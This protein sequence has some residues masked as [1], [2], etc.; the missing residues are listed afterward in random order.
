MNLFLLGSLAFDELYRFDGDF[1]ANLLSQSLDDLSVCFVTGHHEFSFGGCGGN[2][3]FGLHLLACE[4]FV[5]GVLG[6]VDG[7]VYLKRLQSYGMNLNYLTLETGLSSRAHILTDKKGRQIS[8]FNPG[9]SALELPFPSLDLA[10]AG[11]VLFVSPENKNRMMEAAKQGAERG[12]RVFFDPGQMIHVFSKEDYLEIFNMIELLI[13]NHYEWKLLQDITGMNEEELRSKV[14]KIVLTLSSKG[15]QYF[16]EGNEH[17]VDA[18]EVDEANPTGSGE[19]FRA[20]LL[21]S[22]QK[23]LSFEEGLN[24]GS[25]LGAICASHA[26]TQDYSFG[27]DHMKKLESLGFFS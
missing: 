6:N 23:G 10:K 22:L 26:K 12:M 20:G 16:T 3:A 2:L 8:H 14:S 7:E 11:D 4:A 5:I 21:A 27:P 9:V 19:A 25:I 13:L 15:A 1:K 24:V 17:Q 18:H